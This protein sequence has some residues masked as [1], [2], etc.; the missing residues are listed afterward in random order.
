MI[1][2]KVMKKLLLVFAFVVGVAHTSSAQSDFSLISKFLNS[3]VNQDASSM[4]D[5]LHPDCYGD[6]NKLMMQSEVLGLTGWEL[7]AA[8]TDENGYTSYTSY[9]AAMSVSDEALLTEAISYE[10]RQRLI[11][12]IG[13]VF[14]Y[15]SLYVVND[16]G[17]K[18]VRCNADL[19]SIRDVEQ[20]L[21]RVGKYLPAKYYEER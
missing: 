7:V 3:V 2:A 8:I 20:E 14:A 15:E 18:Y 5:V 21:R 1:I 4:M 6:V 12:P 19:L 11:A 16:G 17:R 13:C 10:D 9:I